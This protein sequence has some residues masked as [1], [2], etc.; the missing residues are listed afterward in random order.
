MNNVIKLSSRATQEFWEI[1]VLFEDECLLALNKPSRL[2]TSPDHGAPNRPDLMTLLHR[3]ITRGAPWVVQRR[4]T[5]LANTHRLDFETSGV[6]LLAK[7]KPVLVNLAN[8][9]GAEKPQKSYLALV[10]G[11]PPETQFQINA[12][13]APHPI[14]NGSVRVD[15][16]GGKK[17]RTDFTVLER[18]RGYAL[19]QCQPWTARP[20]QIRVHLQAQGFPLAADSLYGGGPFY[21]SSLKPT[22]RL[23]R[24]RV[25]RPLLEDLALHAE[26]ITFEHPLTKAEVKITAPW[27]K[28]FKTAIKYLRQLAL[29]SGSEALSQN[30]PNPGDLSLE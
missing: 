28:Y 11:N 9:F 16:K 17:A 12:K 19:L 5:Y 21:L 24:N 22:Y 15:A 23:K 27:P 25:E 30:T 18:Y 6:L 29:I 2:L 3:D 26:T 7:E 8:Q 10:Q 20:H 4:V 14:R 13:L 1:P